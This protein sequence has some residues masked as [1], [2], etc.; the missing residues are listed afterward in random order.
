MDWYGVA[1]VSMIAIA[2]GWGAGYLGQMYAM[3]HIRFN[4]PELKA[5]VHDVM[6][7]IS[8]KGLSIAMVNM[9]TLQPDGQ[10]E[11]IQWH[12]TQGDPNAAK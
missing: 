1:G 10:V 4:T 9:N 6:M 11:M 12:S 3:K 2:S 8:R 5:G 7:S